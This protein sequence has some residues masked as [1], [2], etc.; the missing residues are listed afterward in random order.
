MARLAVRENARL[1]GLA[2][3]TRVARAFAGAV[4]G[5]GHPCGMSRSCWRALMACAS[6]VLLRLT[7]K[8]LSWTGDNEPLLPTAPSE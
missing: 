8:P 3:R 2:D 1:A 7:S 4:L 6:A 5:P